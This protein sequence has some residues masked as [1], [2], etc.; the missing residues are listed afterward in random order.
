MS[1][2]IL[3]AA[4]DFFSGLRR[5]NG[6]P[7]GVVVALFRGWMGRAGCT[8]PVSFSSRY[9]RADLFHVSIFFPWE[10]MAALAL[11]RLTYIPP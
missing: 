5:S 9:L 8:H 11:P 7:V 1:E 6:H 3:T 2:R 10:P 4:N